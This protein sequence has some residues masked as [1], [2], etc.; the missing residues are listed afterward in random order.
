MSTDWEMAES[1]GR[2][3]GIYGIRWEEKFRQRYEQEMINLNETHFYV[4]TLRGHPGTWIIVGLF[5]PRR[6]QRRLENQARAKRAVRTTPDIAP[7]LTASGRGP[8]IATLD[9]REI[10]S[11]ENG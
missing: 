6:A 3:R 9:E 11:N 2:W 8:I 4:G 10:G 7:T 5:Y 1:Y